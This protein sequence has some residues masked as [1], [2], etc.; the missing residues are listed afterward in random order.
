M[1]LSAIENA[2][3]SSAYEKWLE[4]RASNPDPL[5]GVVQRFGNEDGDFK[6]T[7]RSTLQLGRHPLGNFAAFTTDDGRSGHGFLWQGRN[8]FTSKGLFF[9]NTWEDITSDKI[10]M[11]VFGAKSGVCANFTINGKCV[12]TFMGSEVDA[13]VVSVE[14][15]FTWNPKQD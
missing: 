9:Y 14:G 12:G 1:F 5:A 2:G 10:E 7:I 8:E 6:N 3:G 15:G 11:V 13:K 4:V